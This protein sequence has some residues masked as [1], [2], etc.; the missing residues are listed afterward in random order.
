MKH[1]LHKNR[2]VIIEG[3]DREVPHKSLNIRLFIKW[4]H[5]VAKGMEYLSSKNIM[6]GDLAARNILITNCHQDENYLAKVCDFGLSKAFYDKTSYKKQDRKNVPWKWMAVDYFETGMFTM[7]SDVWSFGVVFWEMLS[8]GRFP[9]AGGNQ[10]DTI[11]EII[12][13][14]RLPVPDEISEVQ[15]LKQ[16]Y[17]EVAKMC[18]QLD[19]KQRSSFSD[20][21]KTFETYLTTDEK[22]NLR[23]LDQN[24]TK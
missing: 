23:R 22:E 6:H 12:L 20:L 14:F 1:F 15:W 10:N 21:V 9:Y 24:I 7:T 11:A 3:L 8:M 13:G 5:G 18:W 4:G 17:E 16:C 2:D 19:P